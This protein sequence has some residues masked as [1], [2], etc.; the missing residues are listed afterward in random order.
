MSSGS[1]PTTQIDGKL[2]INVDVFTPIE[3]KHTLSEPAVRDDVDK[4]ITIRTQTGCFGQEHGVCAKSV[5]RHLMRLSII[6]KIVFKNRSK[7]P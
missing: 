2:K 3:I 1:D 4:L 7:S 6:V 5:M